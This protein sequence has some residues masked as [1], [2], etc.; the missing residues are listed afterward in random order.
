MTKKLLSVTEHH[1][2]IDE[3][4][5]LKLSADI[6]IS[7]AGVSV[8]NGAVYDYAIAEPSASINETPSTSIPHGADSGEMAAFSRH[9]TGPPICSIYTS[10]TTETAEVIIA[11]MD[12][13]TLDITNT[14][15]KEVD[16][17]G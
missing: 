14:Y 4:R 10:R 17:A 7:S 1:T 6:S 15:G 5:R 9:L 13:A 11:F 16:Y 12:V 8:T 3:T 2:F